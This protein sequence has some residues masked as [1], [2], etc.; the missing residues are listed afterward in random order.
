MTKS[1]IERAFDCIPQGVVICGEFL[2]PNTK[3]AIA[4]VPFFTDE[5]GIH[6][7]E[8][9]GD[10]VGDLLVHGNRGHW[11]ITTVPS[12]T[13]LW[14]SYYFDDGDILATKSGMTTLARVISSSGLYLPTSLN[15]YL[16][17]THLKGGE[18]NTTLR[19]LIIQAYA[20]QNNKV[21]S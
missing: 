8:L 17:G 19:D 11:R 12:G 18:F 9:Q 4:R 15:D 3:N 13:L 21:P 16:L 10:R 14:A 20:I 5:K 6:Y 2:S 1:V 7:V